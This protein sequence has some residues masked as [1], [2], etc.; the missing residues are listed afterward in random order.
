MYRSQIDDH[1]SARSYEIW[2]REGRESGRADEYWDR[3]RQEVEGEIRA[4]IEGRTTKVVLP[5]LPI[6]Q[7]PI[8][9]DGIQ[10]KA[11]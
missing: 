3:A 6:S 8:R 1:I 5:H 2:E 10:S 4:A 7:R 11:A 9:Y